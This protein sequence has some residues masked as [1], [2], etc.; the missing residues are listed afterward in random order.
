LG[1]AGSREKDQETLIRCY[2][3][4]ND[5]GALI[6]NVDAEYTFTDAWPLWLKEN[7]GGLPEP[8]P[9]GP[10]IDHAA[11]GSEYRTWFRRLDLNPL[12]QSFTSQVR[13]EKWQDGRLVAQE[14]LSLTGLMYFKN[15]LLLMLQVAG[16][17]DVAIYGDYSDQEA[18][19]ENRELIFVAQ[20]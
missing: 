3:H 14:E 4:L 16:F 15:E 1:L 2:E 9:D 10:E 19:A 5:G 8:W 20:K 6:F 11:D 12:E 18:T 7:R 13:I 17:D